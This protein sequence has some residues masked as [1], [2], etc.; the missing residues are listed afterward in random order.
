MVELLYSAPQ[1]SFVK[2]QWVFYK[3]KRVGQGLPPGF[4]SFGL[5]GHL[6]YNFVKT[7]EPPFFKVLN[8]GCFPGSGTTTD[9]YA[10]Y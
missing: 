5:K 7:V 4:A 8:K 3:G 9:Y 1:D 10:L 6:P 2:F